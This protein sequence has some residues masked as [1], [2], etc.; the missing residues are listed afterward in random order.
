MVKSKHVIDENL[1]NVKEI[2]IPKFKVQ[3]YD[4]IYEIKGVH[5]LF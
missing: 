3:G 1:G 4:Q 5:I 2:Y